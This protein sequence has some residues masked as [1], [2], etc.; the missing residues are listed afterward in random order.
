MTSFVQLF[1]WDLKSLWQDANKKRCLALLQASRLEEALEAHQFM[2]DKC[3]ESTKANSLDW[4]TGKFSAM[5]IT[6]QSSPPFRAAFEQQCSQ[7]YSADAGDAALKARDYDKAIYLYSVAIDLGDVSDTIFAKRSK[8]KLEKMLWED[9]LL[10]AQKVRQYL[11]FY[12]LSKTHF[13]DT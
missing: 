5:S 10:D 13:C 12:N 2:M 3:D 1:G 7:Q 4:S 8:A 11:L 6:L 9:A